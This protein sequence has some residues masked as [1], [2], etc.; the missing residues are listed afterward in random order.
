MSATTSAPA[1]ANST[2]LKGDT[3]CA[4]AAETNSAPDIWMI[5]DIQGCVAPLLSLLS[6]PD[7]ASNPNARFWFAGDLVNRGPSSLQTLR[8]L[9]S[10][11]DR[12]VF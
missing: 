10:I 7:I 6:H 3:A 1:S 4:T 5:G 8:H 12:G 11:E 2:A 9:M